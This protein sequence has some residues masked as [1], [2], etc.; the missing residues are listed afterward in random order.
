MKNGTAVYVFPGEMFQRTTT[1]GTEGDRWGLVIKIENSANSTVFKCLGMVPFFRPT[2]GSPRGGFDHSTPYNLH[3]RRTMQIQ[4]SDRNA[5][6]VRTLRPTGK[7]CASNTVFGKVPPPHRSLRTTSNNC[8]A[9]RRGPGILI[10]SGKGP[11]IT[12]SG[13][14]KDRNG[15][16]FYQTAGRDDKSHS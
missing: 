1:A 12:D 13:S 14:S 6:F 2:P 8:K 10:C 11:S 4:H 9:A 5:A 7:S 15:D 16:S 3:H